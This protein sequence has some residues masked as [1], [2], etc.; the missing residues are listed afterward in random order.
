LHVYAEFIVRPE[1]RVPDNREPGEEAGRTLPPYG[2]APPMKQ[3]HP[4]KKKFRTPK[5]AVSSKSP[6]VEGVVALNGTARFGDTLIRSEK[7]RDFIR[8][9]AEA[10]A[11]ADA[12]RQQE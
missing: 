2:S 10:A 3:P 1:G 9:L 7:F 11:H 4:R 5:E 8:V 6:C 12:T